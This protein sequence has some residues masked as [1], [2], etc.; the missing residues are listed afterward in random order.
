MWDVSPPA[1]LWGNR[2]LAGGLAPP[3]NLCSGLGDPETLF[4]GSTDGRY[5]RCG[6]ALIGR[7]ATP[8]PSYAY[9]GAWMATKG[10][11]KLQLIFHTFV[12]AMQSNFCSFDVNVA[13][14]PPQNPLGLFILR[15]ENALELK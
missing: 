4:I 2:R 12:R 7:F 9:F 6:R 10:L 15:A 11:W 1:E 13:L 14:I 8:R 5:A 3:R